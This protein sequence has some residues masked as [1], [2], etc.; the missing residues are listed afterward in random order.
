MLTLRNEDDLY[1]YEQI[2]EF[3]KRKLELENE[4]YRSLE[5]ICINTNT[6]KKNSML[7]NF[8][9]LILDGELEKAKANIERTENC[10]KKFPMFK[11]SIKEKQA[12]AKRVFDVIVAYNEEFMK[13]QQE[14]DRAEKLYLASVKIRETSREKY[15]DLSNNP[16]TGFFDR[17]DVAT[18]LENVFKP[19]LFHVVKTE[20]ALINR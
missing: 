6:K 7:N 1:T 12:T 16:K 2:R 19:L 3:F 4:Y 18:K 5:K 14:K 8:I 17:I 9:Q 13:A 15:E 20:M 10:A 11:E